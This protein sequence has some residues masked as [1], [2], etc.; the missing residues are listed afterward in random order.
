M[1][2]YLLY[3]GT[4]TEDAFRRQYFRA[5]KFAE[6]ATHYAAAQLLRD[7]REWN[8]ENDDYFPNA[9]LC[10]WVAACHRCW[11]RAILDGCGEE[12]G[13]QGDIFETDKQRDG[14]GISNEFNNRQIAR[15]ESSSD[16]FT[17]LH[18]SAVL[19]SQS[20][21]AFETGEADEGLP[22][23]YEMSYSQVDVNMIEMG[24]PSHIDELPSGGRYHDLDS[25]HGDSC[26]IPSPPFWITSGGRG[27][28]LED[29]DWLDEYVNWDN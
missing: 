6:R 21:L 29:Q 3:S 13:T 17:P 24:N 12:R 22:T 14:A 26:M 4:Q 19:G 2:K 23:A 18:E 7:H 27:N 15:A 11:H 16:M 5:I 8:E 20:I 28:L 25:D 10:E 1:L 9:S